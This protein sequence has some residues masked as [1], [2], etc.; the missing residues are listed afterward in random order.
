MFSFDTNSTGPKF[1]QIGDLVLKWDKAHEDKGEHTKFRKMW[2]GP[3]QIIEKIGSSTFILQDL[4]R[5]RDSLP[6]S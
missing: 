2:L 3:L 1:L 6:V 4:S 5:K